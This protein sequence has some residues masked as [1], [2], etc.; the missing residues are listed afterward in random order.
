ML[1]RRL[2][3]AMATA[4]VLA[5]MSAGP[6]AAGA[7]P[8]A[9]DDAA[10]AF[11]AASGL[12]TDGAWLA[13]VTAGGP[14]L[15]WGIPLSA[16]EAT[17]LGRRVSITNRLDAID[18]ISKEP[19]F[20]GIWIDQ[21]ARGQV[22]IR[23]SG[24]PKVSADTLAAAL[25]ASASVRFESTQYSMSDLQ[26]LRDQLRPLLDDRSAIKAGLR[27]LGIDVTTNRVFIGA[28]GGRA[29]LPSW[30]TSKLDSPM[31]DVREDFDDELVTCT[32][33]NCLPFK[34]GLWLNSHLPNG[35]SC[36]AGFN[37]H[38]DLDTSDYYKGFSITSGHC[39]DPS[40]IGAYYYHPDNAG[41]VLGTTRSWSYS[42][43]ANADAGIITLKNAP[44][45][46]NVIY[47]GYPT[48]FRSITHSISNAS[49][50]VNSYMCKYG[51]ASSVGYKCGYISEVDTTHVVDAGA[52][53]SIDHL[54]TFPAQSVPGDSGGPVFV[55]DGAGGITVSSHLAN[56]VYYTRYSSI[57]WVRTVTG[58]RPCYVATYPC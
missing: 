23:T 17:E 43:G 33:E 1:S 26:S 18:W 28:I 52:G 57:A 4:F 21:L 42:N 13:L 32:D 38:N 12:R 8:S 22:V 50:P 15:D 20:A 35:G 49:Q 25:P 37:G 7:Q 11:R 36:T 16:G 47:W 2:R 34:G 56:G 9:A 5:A 48:S 27:S 24:D 31:L 6:N 40:G 53:I 44:T 14:N 58:F 19:W 39:V 3:T 30:L 51:A 10:I 41:V 46:A 54:W 45:P 55:V 29:S